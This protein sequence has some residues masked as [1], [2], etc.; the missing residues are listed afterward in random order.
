MHPKFI[1]PCAAF[2]LSTAPALA[3]RPVIDYFTGLYERIGRDAEGKLLQGF[4]RLDVEGATLQ[5]SQ[6]PSS[7]LAPPL[8]LAYDDTFETPNFLSGREG[9]FQLACQYFN[10]SQNYPILNCRSDGGAVFTLWP[11]GSETGCPAP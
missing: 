10:D 1:A 6:C 9:P 4:V 5:L 8:T 7:G 2:I 11:M 3:D